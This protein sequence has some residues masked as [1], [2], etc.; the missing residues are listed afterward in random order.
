MELTSQTIKA[1]TKYVYER[2]PD[3]AGSKPQVQKRLISKSKTDLPEGT[4]L[5]I[6]QKTAHSQQGIAIQRS[7]RVIV[8][9]KGEILRISTSR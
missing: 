7:I 3:I 4:F 1:I 9:Q 6:F 8:N 5:V 2:F